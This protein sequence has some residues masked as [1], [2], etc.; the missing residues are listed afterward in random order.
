MPYEIQW[1][2]RCV[3][4]RMYGKIDRYDL[5]GVYREI[6][7]NPLYD[8]LCWEI[9]DFLAVT[10]LAY[11]V[12]DA[13]AYGHM[14]MGGGAITNPQINMAIV[15]TNEEVLAL[16][17]LYH[18]IIATTRWELKVFPTLEQAQQWV[19]SGLINP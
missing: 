17:S 6:N 11:S 7:N 16:S 8:S 5:K 3:Y 2:D 10:E 15:S 13:E 18:S 19:K 4:V 14:D 9:H 1:E 12:D